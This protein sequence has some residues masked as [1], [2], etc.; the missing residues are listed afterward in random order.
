MPARR[1]SDVEAQR[2]WSSEVGALR[3]EQESLA[4]D[5]KNVQARADDATSRASGLE[6]EVSKLQGALK[7]GARQSEQ[8]QS[9]LEQERAARRTA[10]EG[11]TALSEKNSG[12]QAELEQTRKERERL[13]QDALKAAQELEA[14][15]ARLSRMEQEKAGLTSAL[16]GRGA[17]LEDAVRELRTAVAARELAEDRER[18]L[19]EQRSKDEARLRAL[20]ERVQDLLA[21]RAGIDQELQV[22]RGALK[23]VEANVAALCNVQRRMRASDRE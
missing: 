18:V 21:Q 7:S 13:S 4:S 20:E 11:A 16:E 9:A 14:R 5:L 17:E 8:L 19:R 3:S 6:A 15:G 10:A 23:N 22:A 1:N 12:L 2:Q